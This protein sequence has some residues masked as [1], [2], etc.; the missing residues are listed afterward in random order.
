MT[1]RPLSDDDEADAFDDREEK[2]SPEVVRYQRRG[3]HVA[4][5]EDQNPIAVV[6]IPEPARRRRWCTDADE[7]V[8][9]EDLAGHAAR[10]P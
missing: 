2:T 5:R 8:E 1:E 3:I 7:I 4:G 10:L 9:H 6:A